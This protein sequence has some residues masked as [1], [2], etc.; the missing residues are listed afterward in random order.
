M[1]GAC[2]ATLPAR[3]PIAGRW[4]ARRARPTCAT[5]EPAIPALPIEN[6]AGGQDTRR[7]ILASPSNTLRQLLNGFINRGGE[8]EK[9]KAFVSTYALDA[10][11]FGLHR[12][13]TGLYVFG[14]RGAY[15]A[16]S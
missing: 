4:T 7:H 15:P 14:S 10:G 13:G 9:R 1:S 2:P 5:P 11:T 8:I 16:T 6:F 3:R 12:V